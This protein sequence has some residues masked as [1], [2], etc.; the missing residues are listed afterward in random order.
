[1][2]LGYTK[3]YAPVT[4]TVSVRAARQ[5]E[6]LNVGQPIVTIVDLSDT[7]VRAAIPETQADHIGLG[8]TLRI[9]FPAEQS[10]PA[11]CSSNLRKPTSPRNAT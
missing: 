10:L 6:V 1:M 2:R 4:G 8:D 7:W 11:K 5:G 3:I 9:R